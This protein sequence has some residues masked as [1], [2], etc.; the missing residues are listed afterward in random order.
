MVKPL[1]VSFDMGWQKRD[2]PSTHYHG[3]HFS[4]IWTRKVWKNAFIQKMQKVLWF[5]RKG[6]TIGCFGLYV[7]RISLFLSRLQPALY[8]LMPTDWNN[9]ATAV[10]R[11]T[12]R[13]LWH[14]QRGR[15]RF[16]TSTTIGYCDDWC[17]MR[18]SWVSKNSDRNLKY[19]CK[20]TKQTTA[21]NEKSKSCKCF[22]WSTRASGG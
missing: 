22:G 12:R 1:T 18:E 2:Y 8:S 14:F 15:N 20:V 9:F 19:R 11:T 10:C 3:S 21:Q 6:F 17:S 5:P 7:F 4:I 16:C 13:K